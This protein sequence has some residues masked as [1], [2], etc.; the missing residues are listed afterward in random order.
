VVTHSVQSAEAP[1][2]PPLDVGA[3]VPV[4]L[5]APPAPP[6]PC[7]PEGPLA[8]QEA[9][10]T[11][12]ASAAKIPH[13][14]RNRVCERREREGDDMVAPYLRNET[15]TATTAHLQAEAHCRVQSVTRECISKNWPRTVL[16]DAA[17]H[18]RRRLAR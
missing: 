7:V 9:P 4:L 18:L 11:T 15:V 13:V 12:E 10:T 1:P 14:L 3:A 5:P 8:A 16:R 17:L 2:V 6:V